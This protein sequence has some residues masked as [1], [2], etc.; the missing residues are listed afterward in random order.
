[1]RG[2][3]IL[4]SLEALFSAFPAGERGEMKMAIRAYL[5]ALEGIESEF[6]AHA[7]KRFIQGNVDRPR[8]GFLPSTDELAREARR[9]SDDERRRRTYA[10]PPPPKEQ[11]IVSAEERAKVSALMDMLAERMAQKSPKA[12]R[13]TLPSASGLTPDE[14]LDLALKRLASTAPSAEALARLGLQLNNERN[15]A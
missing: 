15:P 3:T 9:L 12:G 11:P 6:V 5:M 14:E 2:P 13:Y 4:D 8:Y 7:V 1:M 10:L